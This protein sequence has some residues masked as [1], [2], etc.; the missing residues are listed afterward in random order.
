MELYL[1]DLQSKIRDR[2]AL[3]KKIMANPTKLH[4]IKKN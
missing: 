1:G 3:I 2:G 4:K